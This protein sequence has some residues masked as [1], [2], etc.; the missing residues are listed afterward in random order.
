MSFLIHPRVSS[1][2]YVL[3]LGVEEGGGAWCPSSMVDASQREWLEVDFGGLRLVTAVATQGRHA[4]GQ[5][6]EYTPAYTL[7]YWRPGMVDFT[8]Y[9][10]HPSKANKVG[11]SVTSLPVVTLTLLWYVPLSV[12]YTCYYLLYTSATR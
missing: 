1:S 6:Q 5:G 8:F 11:L 12:F 7:S 9:S 4:N 2:L 10:A 3:R